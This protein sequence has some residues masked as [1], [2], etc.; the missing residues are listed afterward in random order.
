MHMQ[1][2]PETMQQAPAYE[3]VVGEVAAFFADRL[4]RLAAAGVRR[5]QVALDVGIG[6]GK[7]VE[8]NLR[9]LAA[10]ESFRSFSRPLVLGV[11]RKSFLGRLLGGENPESRLPGALACTLWAAERG[12]GIVRTHDVAATR[13]ALQMTETLRLRAAC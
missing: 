2:L 10:L 5:E 1:G 6:F 8:H 7:T 12:A 11:S 3:D 9:L 13:Q 4:G